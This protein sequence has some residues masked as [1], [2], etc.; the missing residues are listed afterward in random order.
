MITIMVNWSIFEI[1]Y[2]NFLVDLI[3]DGTI[4]TDYIISYELY[5]L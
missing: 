2:A 4:Q 1:S 5:E 3:L